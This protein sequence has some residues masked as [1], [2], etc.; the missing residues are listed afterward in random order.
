MSTKIRKKKELPVEIADLA[1]WINS[2]L[3]TAVPHSR[4]K[5]VIGLSGGIDSAVAAAICTVATGANHVLGVILPCESPLEDELDAIQIAGKL[6]IYYVQM[7]LEDTFRLW[8]DTY[9]HSVAWP[10]QKDKIFPPMN[11]LVKANAKSRLRMLT[12]YALANQVSG[13][14]IGTTNK[15]EAAIGYA[16]KYGDGGVDIEPLMDFYKTE[17][18]EMAKVLGVPQKIINRVPSAGLWDGQT[19]EDEIG[20]SYKEIDNIL[21]HLLD[22]EPKIDLNTENVAKVQWMIKASLHK[23]IHLPYYERHL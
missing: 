21:K 15:T 18:W 3:H 17:I 14:V 9:R 5:A 6:G 4:Y 7:D 13:L 22:N 20:I 12:L 1:H 19:D 16:T 8:W 2:Y 23:N 10:E 11:R